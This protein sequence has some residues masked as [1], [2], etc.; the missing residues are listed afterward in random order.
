MGWA[1]V[2][3]VAKRGATLLSGL[4]LA[5]LLDPESFGVYTI[6][7]TVTSFALAINDL[8]VSAAVSRFRS[9]EVDRR[10]P[11]AAT[12]G[13]L[14]S[15]VVFAAQIAAAPAIVSLFDTAGTTP[16]A[17]GVVR[18]LAVP[19]LVDGLVAAWAGA[20]TRE[21]QEKRRTIAELWGFGASIGLNV[22]L[23]IAGWGPWALACGQVAG[24]LTT[25][26][27]LL[28][29]SPVAIRFGFERATAA[30]LVRFGL[31]MVGA[32][33]LNQ[34][35]LNS[36]FLIVSR[37]LGAAVTGA[38]FLAF[39]VSNWPVTLI[40]FAMR[41][42][43]VAAFARLGDDLDVL[44]R[45][46]SSS[47]RVLVL[48]VLPLVIVVGANARDLL[49]VLYGPQ[50]TIAATA[51]A[52]LSGIALVRLVFALAFELLV[53]LGRTGEI[54]L[55]QFAWLGAVAPAMFVGAARWGL[56]GVGVAQAAAAGLVALP[57][58]LWRLRAVGVPA[59]DLLVPLLR[60]LLAAAL[61][62]GGVV[63]LRGVVDPGVVR[64]GLGTATALTV[65]GLC[66]GL[67]TEL[68]PR[69]RAAARNRG[70]RDDEAAGR[71]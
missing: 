45:A 50:Y 34:L 61:A 21:L 57:L 27:F 38:Y 69:V 24:S 18:L 48:G 13:L 67:V 64:L 36:D 53:A 59:R 42:T 3:Q 37:Q 32:G 19:I 16:E 58:L 12:I 31:P 51:L 66:S 68:A 4:V 71:R 11:T 40:S 41:R 55:V 23:A 14:S 39:N 62:V 52:F 29:W 5:R 49:G 6:A 25:A 28:R 44:R 65:Y 22:A 17:V 8:G 54:F 26:A 60:P 15:G 70:V 7:L 10:I 43:A 20:I 33:V 56:V 35:L 63:A 9:D 30:Q 2:G 46:F 47:V 1:L